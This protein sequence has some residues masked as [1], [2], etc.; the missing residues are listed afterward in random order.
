MDTE[1]M[2]ELIAVTSARLKTY[3]LL[4]RIYRVEADEALLDELASLDLSPVGH[5]RIDEGYRL[6]KRFLASRSEMTLLECA[7]DYVK[8]F[9]GA[10]RSAQ[11]AA[12]PY[13][14]IYTSTERLMMAEARDEV[15]AIY[16]YAGL[17]KSESFKAPE[18]HI[19]LEL[20]FMA[21]LCDTT[22]TA[23][24][25]QD[26][27]KGEDLLS[28]QKDFLTAHLLNWVP[29]DFTS[30]VVRFAT[31]DLYRGLAQ[32]TAGFLATDHEFLADTLTEEES[33]AMAL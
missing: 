5:E 27:A 24:K 23:L 19:A 17:A 13:E 4:A 6:W 21:H 29:F 30:D 1:E 12:Y 15:F 32:V 11:S 16:A 20:E 18:D 7:R 25:E 28:Q 31:T 10:G 22:C 26:L 14:S 3:S 33:E 9:V 8:V 2:N